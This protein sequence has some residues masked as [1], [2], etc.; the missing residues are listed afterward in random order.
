[1]KFTANYFTEASAGGFQRVPV[2]VARE[3]ED[4]F[5]QA[6]TKVD[7]LSAEMRGKVKGMEDYLEGKVGVVGDIATGSNFSEAFVS[8]LNGFSDNIAGLVASESITMA[9][10][11]IMEGKAA[12][13]LTLSELAIINRI[14][15]QIPMLDA[16][17]ILQK[18]IPKDDILKYI[19]GEYTQV[20]GFISTAKDAKH[21]QSFEDIYYGMRLDY[22]GTKF[23]LSD[24]SCGVIRYKTQ[25]AGAAIIPKSPINGG[26]ESGL[27][28]FTGHGFTS[29]N[30]GRLGVPEWKTGYL[31]PMDGAELWE[32]FSNGTEV[33]KGKFSVLQNKFV[34]IQ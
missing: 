28:P 15:S 3:F 8:S 25:G 20:G 19:N 12:S 14:R 32:V 27:M 31:T 10:F 17:T 4:A 11:M 29:G 1:V 13:Q 2:S 6:G 5:H 26:S 24:G 23:S 34:A 18:V 9:E 30:N 16:N 21:L 33:L 7:Q 22:S